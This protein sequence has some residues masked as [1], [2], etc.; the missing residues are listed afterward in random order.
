MT[1]KK[2]FTLWIALLAVVAGVGAQ[3]NTTIR[4]NKVETNELKVKTR[5]IKGISTRGSISGS[6]SNDSLMTQNAIKAY[7]TSVSSSG[8]SDGDKGDVTVSGSGSVWTIDADVIAWGKLS[9]ATKDSIIAGKKRVSLRASK[10][11]TT[12]LADIVVDTVGT[13]SLYVWNASGYMLLQTGSGG[14]GSPTGS[15]GGDLT[16][17]YPNPT[18]GSGKVISANIL[19]G[20]IVGADMATGTVGPTQLANTAV[21]PGTYTNA[22][23]TF[24]A[25][26]RATAASSGGGGVLTPALIT[27]NTTASPG[28]DLYLSDTST[29][30]IT[31]TISPGAFT[32]RVLYVKKIV[33]NSNNVTITPSSGTIDGSPSYILY[34]YNES[35]I[36]FSNGTNLYLL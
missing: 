15:A 29:G 7:V 10:P 8:V 28:V 26:G 11:S 33:N 16:G 12:Y 32:N 3:T 18:I 21:T 25:D 14:G 4:A 9:S 23:V 19:D 30:S 27:T 24:D 22:T 31:V 17:T 34:L 36:I 13:D 6:G 20:T 35:V 2:T 5:N 1:L